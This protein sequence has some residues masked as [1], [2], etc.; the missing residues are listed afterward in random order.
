MKQYLCYCLKTYNMLLVPIVLSSIRCNHHGAEIY[1]AVAFLYNSVKGAQSY[2]VQGLSY[3]RSVKG[4]Q[5]YIPQGL[6]YTVQSKEHRATQCN[7]LSYTVQ[8]N[9]HRA[10]QCKR[11]PIP[12]SQRDTELHSAGDLLYRSVKRTQSYT[13]QWL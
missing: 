8:S 12:F 5:S 6:S 7:G 10:T 13:V 1:G 2:T 3:T 4:T 9:G 11:S